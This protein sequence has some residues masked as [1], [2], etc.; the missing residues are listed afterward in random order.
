LSEVN[1]SI[2]ASS[3]SNDF[4]QI[5]FLHITRPS[6]RSRLKRLIPKDDRPAVFSIVNVTVPFEFLVI[7]LPLPPAA[8][9]ARNNAIQP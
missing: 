9:T 4:N 6:S 5:E 8:P 1:T 2:G 7:P 3:S